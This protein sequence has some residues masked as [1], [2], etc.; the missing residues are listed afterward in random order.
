MGRRLL[1]EALSQAQYVVAEHDDLAELIITG[2]GDLSGIGALFRRLQMGHT[3]R[4]KSLG[5]A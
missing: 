5:L 4:M 1:G 3:Q 2:S